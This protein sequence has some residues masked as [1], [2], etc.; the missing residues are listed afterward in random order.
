[1]KKLASRPASGAKA[2]A[3]RNRIG[4]WHAQAD[5][6]MQSHI[7]NYDDG[8]WRWRLARQCFH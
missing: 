8:G 1:M 5:A 4:G 2:C 7:P 6:G 3:V